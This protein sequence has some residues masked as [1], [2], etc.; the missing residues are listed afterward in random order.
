MVARGGRAVLFVLALAVV[1][2]AGEIQD[3]PY[4]GD[5]LYP[6]CFDLY[7]SAGCEERRVSVPHPWRR[8]HSGLFVCPAGCGDKLAERKA[9]LDLRACIAA[10]AGRVGPLRRQL[11]L[12]V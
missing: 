6:L 3:P 8:R 5:D 2:L 1:V 11:S 10:F 4:C 7:R 12:V 9:A